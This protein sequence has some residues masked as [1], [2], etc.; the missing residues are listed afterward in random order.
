MVFNTNNAF[1][2]IGI[3]Y[4]DYDGNKFK[5]IRILSYAYS[6]FWGIYIIFDLIRFLILAFYPRINSKHGPI[7]YYLCDFAGFIYDKS[8][9]YKII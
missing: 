6:W 1:K 9:K 3:F 4:S 5:K 7:G 2:W 8:Y